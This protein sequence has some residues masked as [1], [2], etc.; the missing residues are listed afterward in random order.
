MQHDEMKTGAVR[1]VKELPRLL[2]DLREVVTVQVHGVVVSGHVDELGARVSEDSLAVRVALE[3][4]VAAFVFDIVAE[5]HQ[6][7][8]VNVFVHGPNDS[9][10]KLGGVIGE[11]S[12]FSLVKGSWTKV[13][14]CDEADL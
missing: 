7:I 14:I 11:L 13:E 6:Q 2:P 8:R 3:V 10:S 4:S 12:K 5:V 1:H 9:R